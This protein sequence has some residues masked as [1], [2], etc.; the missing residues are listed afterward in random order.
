M[1]HWISSKLRMLCFLHMTYKKAQYSL[2]LFKLSIRITVFPLPLP[3]LFWFA[4]AYQYRCC[5]SAS[6]F[7]D[8]LFWSL[9]NYAQE[10]GR[11]QRVSNPRRQR[12][13][14][15]AGGRPGRW[16]AAS[17]WGEQALRPAVSLPPTC[18]LELEG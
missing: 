14:S 12:V 13:T 1:L 4:V 10:E 15:V 18:C 9:A 7:C 8:D 3:L 5:T 11:H 16:P 17:R 6:S 2:I